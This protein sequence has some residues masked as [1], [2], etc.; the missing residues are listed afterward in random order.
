M[1]RLGVG[2]PSAGDGA[3]EVGGDLGVLVVEVNH[4]PGTFEN[5]FQVGDFH[6]AQGV[7]P[8]DTVLEGEST[9]V[10]S[11]ARDETGLTLRGATLTTPLVNAE[12]SGVLASDSANLSQRA[13]R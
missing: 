8:I 9:V 4:V 10:F 1:N 13:G 11:G 12:A 3:H 6:P 2:S 7:A 5:F